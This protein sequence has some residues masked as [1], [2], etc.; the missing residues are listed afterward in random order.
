MKNRDII[1]KRIIA[2]TLCTSMAFAMVGCGGGDSDK[3][4]SST[5]SATNESTTTSAISEDSVI[6]ETSSS[7]SAAERMEQS[8]L[9]SLD[10]S[11]ESVLTA[12]ENAY[13]FADKLTLPIKFDALLDYQVTSSEHVNGD[14]GPLKTH[15]LSDE[16]AEATWEYSN[17]DLQNLYDKS[18]TS[19]EDE[20]GLYLPSLY[21]GRDDKKMTMADFGNAGLWYL[22]QGIG[23]SPDALG[24]TRDDM[25][26][27][28]NER[29]IEKDNDFCILELVNRFGNP[30]YISFY[31]KDSNEVIDGVINTEK[32]DS[33]I[34]ITLV[35]I[36]WIFK[37]YKIFVYS[38][39]CASA[40]SDGSYNSYIDELTLTYYPAEYGDVTAA[41]GE[42]RVS[43]FVEARK[44]MVGDMKLYE[45]VA[46]SFD[47]ASGDEAATTEEA[48]TEQ[49]ASGDSNVVE[50]DV[51]FSEDANDVYA[52]VPDCYKS[53]ESLVL[54][55][56][57]VKGSLHMGDTIYLQKPDGKV[58]EGTISSMEAYREPIE[59]AEAGTEFGCIIDGIGLDE[60]DDIRG[61]QIILKK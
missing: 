48:T 30:N 9:M 19:L 24:V 17:P 37:D 41:C 60:R 25:L 22:S 46:F 35:N 8:V 53:N 28:K 7:S 47:N 39:F 33:G 12:P 26:A 6:E 15:K 20:G 58:L 2:C 56:Q 51:D 42:N 3:S 23:F 61:S 32:E 16:L 14:E 38:S 45:P 44:N 27:L 52:T 43:E 31:S 11:E 54:V 1:V 21:I 59:V 5:D 4:S 18:Y 29:G 34:A 49:T 13:L 40:N 36:G 50:V 55:V 57:V 10:Y